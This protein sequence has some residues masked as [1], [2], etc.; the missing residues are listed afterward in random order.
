MSSVLRILCILQREEKALGLRTV[1][2]GMPALAL[3]LAHTDICMFMV[4]TFSLLA[5]NQDCGHASFCG[6]FFS[7]DYF[8]RHAT[9]DQKT[10][11][12]WLDG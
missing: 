9:T 12:S 2:R 6:L 5:V 7:S 8:Y 3:A 11:Q 1:L 4:S 10:R